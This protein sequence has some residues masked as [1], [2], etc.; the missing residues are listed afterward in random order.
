[1]RRAIEVF[2][3]DFLQG[4]GMTETT[5]AATNLMPTDHRRALPNGGIGEI[6]VRGPQLMRG[7]WNRPEATAEALRDGS[8][9]TGDAG[10]LADEG[11]LFVQDRT[12]TAREVLGGALGPRE[13]ATGTCAS[14]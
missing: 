12:R 3:C 7:H 6:A 14:T 4:Y 13:L 2:G 5:A 10:I 11:F 8:M 9:H 1:L